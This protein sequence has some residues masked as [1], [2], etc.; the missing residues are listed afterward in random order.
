MSKSHKVS[1]VKIL[2]YLYNQIAVWDE[3]WNVILGGSKNETVSGRL[4]RAYLNNPKPVARIFHNMVNA[5]FFWQEDH[6][7]DAYQPNDVTDDEVWSWQ[8]GK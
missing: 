6:C 1:N 3:H 2:Q 5:M 8:K 4:G 7:G